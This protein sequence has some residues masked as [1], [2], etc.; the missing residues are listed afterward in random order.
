[1]KL[2]DSFGPN[3]RMVRMFMAEKGIQLP[4]EEVDLLAGENRQEAFTRKN[5]GAQM[6]AMELDDGTV[7]AET[8]TMCQYL[9]EKYPTPVILNIPFRQR[10]RPN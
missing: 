4:V 6:P 5:P 9:E 10:S 1:M 2:Y 7:I 8:T 3:P